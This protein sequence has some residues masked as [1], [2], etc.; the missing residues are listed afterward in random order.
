MVTCFFWIGSTLFQIQQTKQTKNKQTNPIQ[1]K[2]QRAE[3]LDMQ[4]TSGI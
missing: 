4:K 1:N 3:K 2:K